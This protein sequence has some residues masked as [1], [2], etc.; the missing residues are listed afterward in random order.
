M[1]FM[2]LVTVTV[3]VSVSSLVMLCLIGFCAWRRVKYLHYRNDELK[4][5]RASLDAEECHAVKRVQ[6]GDE[7]NEISVDVDLDAI[8]L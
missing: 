6:D 2:G 7:T 1:V 8:N 5:Q 4:T 3:I